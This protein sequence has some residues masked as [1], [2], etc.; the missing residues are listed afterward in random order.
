MIS[1]LSTDDAA[2]YAAHPYEHRRPTRIEAWGPRPTESAT[3][4]Q[5]VPSMADLMAEL[6]ARTKG[7]K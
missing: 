1:T 4:K 6:A 7:A 2:W 5:P 3:I